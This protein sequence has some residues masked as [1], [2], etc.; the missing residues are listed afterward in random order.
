MLTWKPPRSQSHLQD[1]PFGNFRSHGQQKSR[2]LLNQI[3]YSVQASTNPAMTRY[4]RFGQVT[5]LLSKT[6][7]DHP[8]LLGQWS[9]TGET[10]YLE[11]VERIID[12]IIGMDQPINRPLTNIG[13]LQVA[14]IIMLTDTRRIS[15]G[16][17]ISDIC[18]RR[19]GDLAEVIWEHNAIYDR[20][21][22]E[23][24]WLWNMAKFTNS[25]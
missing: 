1:L 2:L 19:D 25:D 3:Y 17:S 21:T 11:E 6:D 16:P 22:C 13:L 7:E 12:L 14:G 5:G 18:E 24:Y 9:G 15:W 23:R 4:R 8:H 10:Y 20:V